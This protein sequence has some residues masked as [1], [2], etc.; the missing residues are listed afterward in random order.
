MLGLLKKYII[1]LHTNYTGQQPLLKYVP[2]YR[3]S[4]SFVVKCFN[5]GLNSFHGS[6]AS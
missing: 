5:T 1:N 4:D 6:V 3:V 2:P